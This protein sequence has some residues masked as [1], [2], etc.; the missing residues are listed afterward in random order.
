MRFKF[1]IA[2]WNAAPWLVACLESVHTQTDQNFDACV[3]IDGSTDNSAEIVAEYIK[4]KPNFSMIVNEENGCTLK[5]QRQAIEALGCEDDDVIIWLDGD[6]R[7]SNPSVLTTL[8]DH[9]GNSDLYVTYGSYVP[10]PADGGCAPARVYPLECV[11]DRD[12][13]NAS[14]WGFLFN[15]LRTMRYYVYKH[16]PLEYLTWEDGS[17]LTV[18]GDA[19][20][21]FCALEMAGPD[22]ILFI[23]DILLNYTSNN[24]NSDWRIASPEIR[25]THNRIMKMKK[26]GIL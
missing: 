22:R 11:K 16:I 26:L 10:V 18:G 9:Y 8:S 15:H 24:S 1:A 25:R 7:L 23:P 20:E 13:R 6:D 2:S 4:D 19:A 3:V 12:F 17:W 21:M 5:S 14:K